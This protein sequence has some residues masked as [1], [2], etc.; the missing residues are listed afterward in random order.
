MDNELETVGLASVGALGSDKG[1]D[2]A[3][4]CDNCGASIDQRFCSACGQLATNLHRPIWTLIGEGL[5]DS[6][7]LDGRIA[8]TLP[9]LMFRPGKITRAYLDGQRARFVPP[10]RLFLL[11]SLVFFSV[12]FGIGDRLG[13]KDAFHFTPDPDG[14]YNVTRGEVDDGEVDWRE[15][16][17]EDGTIDREAVV[18]T[19]L[20][21]GEARTEEE[22]D[23]VRVFVDGTAD[24]YQN[25]N[26]FLAAVERWLPRLSLFMLPIFTIVL[27]LFYAW[28]R[29]IFV[30]DHIITTLHFQ[31]W[32]Y[33]LSSI[34]MVLGLFVS[35][36]FVAL[37]I[38]AL[39][40]YTF[41]LLRRVY[42]T[43]PISAFLRTALLLFIALI[44]LVSL[45]A[46]VVAISVYD[47][48]S[49]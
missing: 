41:G 20:E 27:T 16:I 2:G 33:L 43:G 29:K 44:A 18:E 40:I 6:F 37:L 30:Y 13:W 3:A 38:P 11:T 5:S 24:L 17:R 28:R 49:T 47:V 12:A 9:V 10:F 35:G 8:R 14:G 36:W 46:G 32:F 42:G 1:S 48:G 4:T 45:L 23:Q 34:L 39:P 31:S 22:I 21:D 26:A 25:Q 7:A 15:F 19:I